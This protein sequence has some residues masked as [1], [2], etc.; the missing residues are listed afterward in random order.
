MNAPPCDVCGGTSRRRREL[1]EW[2]RGGLASWVRWVC[3]SCIRA[4]VLREHFRA[5][6]GHAAKDRGRGGRR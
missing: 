1:A 5:V 4:R 3:T 2:E 6:A